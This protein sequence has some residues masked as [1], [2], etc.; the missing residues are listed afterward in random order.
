MLKSITN[1][2]EKKDENKT[3]ASS[4]ILNARVKNIRNYRQARVGVCIY[5]VNGIVFFLPH[6]SLP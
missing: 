6:F 5:C 1:I 4:L 3:F 2:I